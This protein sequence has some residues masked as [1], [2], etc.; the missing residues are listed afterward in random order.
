MPQGIS[1]DNFN[2]LILLFT[3]ELRRFRLLTGIKETWK[4]RRVGDDSSGEG[5]DGGSTVS[6]PGRES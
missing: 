2:L 3:S 1:N 5:I 6:L 4:L